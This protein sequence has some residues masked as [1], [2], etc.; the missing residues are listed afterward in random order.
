MK[1]EVLDSLVKSGDIVSYGYEQL[2][3][4]GNP[5]ESDS[6]NSE[7]LILIFPSGKNLILDT[8]CSGES[9]NTILMISHGV[10]EQ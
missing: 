7:R 4:D 3:E 2:D 5:G 1:N 9:E 10:G 8:C 6:R